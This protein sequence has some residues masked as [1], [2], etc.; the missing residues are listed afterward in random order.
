MCTARLWDVEWEYGGTG[1]HG[2]GPFATR[3]QAEACIRA[4]GEPG[5]PVLSVWHLNR[6]ILDR[7]TSKLKTGIPGRDSQVNGTLF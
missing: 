6:S 5:W 1:K 7:I 3:G 2:N 4:I